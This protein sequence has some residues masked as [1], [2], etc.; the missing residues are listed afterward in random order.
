[1][2]DFRLS[3]QS[4]WASGLVG[5]DLVHVNGASVEAVGGLRRTFPGVPGPSARM[6]CQGPQWPKAPSGMGDD[7]TR[8]SRL[9]L[10]AGQVGKRRSRPTTWGKV[11]ARETL[12]FK[13][14]RSCSRGNRRPCAGRE[15]SAS[16]RP[17]SRQADDG[18]SGAEGGRSGAI[19]G[20]PLLPP[21]GRQKR[22]EVGGVGLNLKATS[23]VLDPQAALDAIPTPWGRNLLEAGGPPADKDGG[24][25]RFLAFENL[26]PER[27][28]IQKKID[29]DITATKR[30]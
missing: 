1:L 26:L 12:F 28:P 4:L 17:L 3:L 11:G 16:S 8:C 15:R 18:S 29:E 22:C 20:P 19:H 27:F 25:L 13:V 10:V 23:V 7:R 9:A 6:D 14:R 5:A 2:N 24:P 21:A 30:M